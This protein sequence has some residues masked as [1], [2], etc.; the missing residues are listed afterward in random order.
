MSVRLADE[1]GNSVSEVIAACS[2]DARDWDA[3]GTKASVTVLDMQRCCY[4]VRQ[5]AMMPFDRGP[6]HFRA[7]LD[8]KPLCRSLVLVS[9]FDR[10]MSSLD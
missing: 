10:Y 3:D 9:L 8:L 7:R 5:T 1:R 6:T 2:S 4:I